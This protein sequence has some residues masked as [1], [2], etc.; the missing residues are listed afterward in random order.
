MDLGNDQS[1]TTAG[2]TGRFGQSLRLPGSHGLADRVNPTQDQ[3][4]QDEKKTATGRHTT[5]EH[6]EAPLGLTT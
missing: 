5:V 4:G 1:T 2:R 3:P 6:T